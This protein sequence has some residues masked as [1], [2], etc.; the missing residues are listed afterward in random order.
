LELGT[1]ILGL[2]GLQNG[3]HVVA[4]GERAREALNDVDRSTLGRLLFTLKKHATLEADL[5]ARFASALQARNRLIHGF[6]EKHNFK[7]QTEAGRDEMIVDLEVVHE[8]LFAAW[9]LASGAT[10]ILTNILVEQHIK[11]RYSQGPTSLN[12]S[13]KP[14]NPSQPRYR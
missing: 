1:L 3:W 12:F 7:I 11:A 9:Q 10:K 14:A 13:H 4:D 8:E 5:E 2:R 6:F